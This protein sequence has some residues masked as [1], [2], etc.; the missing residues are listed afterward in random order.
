M[1]ATQG[2]THTTQTVTLSINDLNDNN[3]VFSSS[4]TAN[5]DENKL[6]TTVVYDANATD[7]DTAFGNIVYSLGGA[8]AGLVNIDG[9][10]GEVRLNASA[11]LRRR[12]PT[13]STSSPRRVLPP[14]RGM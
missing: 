8:D 10:T 6:N 1:I 7:A 14:Q 12:T 5:V 9:A 11:S 4:T 3:P 2:S 13:C